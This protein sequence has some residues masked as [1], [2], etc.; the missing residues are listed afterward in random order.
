MEKKKDKAWLKFMAIIVVLW[1]IVLVKDSFCLIHG[2]FSPESV[3]KVAWDAAVMIL[4]TIIL[5]R[6]CQSVRKQRDKE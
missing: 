4:T 3:K 1:S 2:A 6:K 5:V